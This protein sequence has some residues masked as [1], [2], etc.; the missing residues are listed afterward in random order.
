MTIDRSYRTATATRV[1]CLR[2]H[3][4]LF[5][6]QGPLPRLCRNSN[7]P[8]AAC[9]HDVLATPPAAVLG[10]GTTVLNQ[11]RLFVGTPDLSRKLRTLGAH[12]QE[13]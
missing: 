7:H 2:P 12:I 8:Q 10:A 1:A 3:D 13:S 9:M 5:D 6:G 11:P 4:Q